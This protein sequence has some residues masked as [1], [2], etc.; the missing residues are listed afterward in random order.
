M[1]KTD[2]IDILQGCCSTLQRDY[3][4]I[5]IPACAAG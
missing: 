3:G 5:L 4:I 1:S 2:Y